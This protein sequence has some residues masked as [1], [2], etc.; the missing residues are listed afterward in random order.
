MCGGSFLRDWE[1]Y[2]FVGIYYCAECKSTI[3]LAASLFMFLL[4]NFPF[5]DLYLID[6]EYMD[7][8]RN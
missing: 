3:D 5:I 4:C 7:L 8:I 6:D 1:I 2:G